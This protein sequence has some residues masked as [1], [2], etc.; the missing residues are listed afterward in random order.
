M[1]GR[2]FKILTENEVGWRA[3]DLR[4]PTGASAAVGQCEY[5]QFLGTSKISMRAENIGL[6]SQGFSPNKTD[7][8]V[9][10]R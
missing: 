4:Y 9:A 7:S 8:I 6:S 2:K 5:C 10:R 3:S 1:D